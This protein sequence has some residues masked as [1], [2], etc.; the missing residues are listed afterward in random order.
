MTARTFGRKTIEPQAGDDGLAERRRAFVAAERARADRIAESDVFSPA[1]T[2]LRAS[3]G[4]RAGAGDDRATEPETIVEEEAAAP[5]PFVPLNRS[6]PATW[7]LWLVTGLAG[8]HRFYLG[9]TITG[10]IQAA[11][12][13]ASLGTGIVVQYYPAFAG[14]F[15]SWLWFFLDGLKLRKMYREATGK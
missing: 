9:R 11:I 15:L 3:F 14:L 7:A 12:F 5:E 1:G 2:A 8:G 4:A 13:T 10:G 6:L